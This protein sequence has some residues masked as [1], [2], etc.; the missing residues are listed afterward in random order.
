MPPNHALDIQ[1]KEIYRIFPREQFQ[2]IE[3]G[4][5]EE[6]FLRNTM[7]ALDGAH[8]QSK[9]PL[10]YCLTAGIDSRA[11]IAI[12]RQKHLP[13]KNYF[14]FRCSKW[15]TYVDMRYAV[16]FCKKRGLKLLRASIYDS[17]ASSDVINALLSNNYLKFP[18][19]E[20]SLSSSMRKNLGFNKYLMVNS[21]ILE[22]GRSWFRQR[23]YKRGIDNYPGNTSYCKMVGFDGDTF[24]GYDTHKLYFWEQQLSGYVIPQFMDS[25]IACDFYNPYNCR[26]TI[27][28]VVRSGRFWGETQER[29]IE[30]W[31]K[32]G[33]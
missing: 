24:M 10:L 33:G 2:P 22:I 6:V 17:K 26:H 9:V 3:R 14:T 27:D 20:F 1:A 21:N 30:E 28:T 19:F 12:A 23:V 25:D 11:T 13:V 4:I 5:G 8:H 16:G 7:N 29:L 15:G 31:L 32:E 18:H